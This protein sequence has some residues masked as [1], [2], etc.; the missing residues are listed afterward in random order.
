M[1]PIGKLQR[2]REILVS[3]LRTS[4]AQFAQNQRPTNRVHPKTTRKSALIRPE[5]QSAPRAKWV[6]IIFSSLF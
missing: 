3:P 5:L 4:L 2:S 1:P 6:E